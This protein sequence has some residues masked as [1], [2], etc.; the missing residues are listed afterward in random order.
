MYY[1][2]EIEKP[3]PKDN[4]V[5]I[6]VYA[7]TVTAGDIRMRRFKVPASFWLPARIALGITG[8][9]RKILGMEMSGVIESVGKNVFKFKAGDEVCAATG[10]GGGYAQYICLPEADVFRGQVIMIIKKPVNL[11]FEQAVSVPVGAITA[12]A[13]IRDANIKNGQKI[14]IYGASGS[15]G[16][17][18]VQLVK[19]YG[20]EVTGVCSTPNMELVK[21]LG[22]A[23]VIDY[24]KE[25]FHQKPS[26]L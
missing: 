1:N 25:D 11:T 7:T 9:K 21:S 22:A 12:L 19:N 6:K 13:F 8:P 18:F 26:N 3:I 4:Q 20:A 2:Y 10:F 5:L 23:K 24:T 15:V 17:Y 14:L 16:T